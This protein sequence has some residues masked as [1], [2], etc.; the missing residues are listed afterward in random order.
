M[1]IFLAY[2]ITQRFITPISDF[3][4]IPWVLVAVV[5]IIIGGLRTKKK[6]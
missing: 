6:A 5:L 4:A 1:L 3:I 2:T